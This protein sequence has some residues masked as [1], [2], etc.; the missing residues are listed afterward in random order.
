VD[1]KLAC[2]FEYSPDVSQVGFILR[3]VASKRHF[4]MMVLFT[5]LFFFWFPNKQTLKERKQTSQPTGTYTQKPSW[6][7]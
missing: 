3:F 4:C 1:Q 2:G 6:D 7:L 5:S